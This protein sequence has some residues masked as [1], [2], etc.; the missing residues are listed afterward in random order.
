[1]QQ[2]ARHYARVRA[3]LKPTPLPGAC[4][5]TAIFERAATAA[6]F[7][8]PER[9]ELAVDWAARDSRSGGGHGPASTYLLGC[10]HPGKQTLA[11]TYIPRA[12]GRGADVRELSEVDAIEREGGQYVV[13]WRDHATRRRYRARSPRVILAAGTLGT[14]R[15]LFAARDR[16]RALE[17]PTSLGEHF[18]P[19]GDMAAFAYRCKGAEGSPYGPCGGAALRLESKASQPFLIAE[20]G[21]P[22]ESLP[23]PR[24]LRR[25][26]QSSI[27]VGRDGT[28][29]LRRADHLRRA[30]AAHAHEPRDR[31]RALRGGRTG[32]RGDPRPGSTRSAHFQTSPA[33]ARATGCCQCIR[34]AEHRS[35]TPPSTAS[36][37]TPERSSATPACSSRTPPRSRARQAFRRR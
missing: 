12:V 32:A 19:G 25:H 3:T 14:L 10:E 33:A 15:L 23:L 18:S 17:L 35:R 27:V 13:H 20:T 16:D 6:G 8:S 5:R 37:T 9:P 31:P 30:R 26:L 34:W 24:R 21:V 36:S 29:R 11:R 2:M 28:R 7:A 4:A 22:L 1:M